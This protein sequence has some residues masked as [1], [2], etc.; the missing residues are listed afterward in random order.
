MEAMKT[1]DKTMERMQKG[2]FTL[3]DMYNQFEVTCVARFCAVGCLVLGLFLPSGDTVFQW[4]M[5][6]SLLLF[7]SDLSEST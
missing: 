1:D 3:R 2:E 5:Y 4:R 6:L 7:F